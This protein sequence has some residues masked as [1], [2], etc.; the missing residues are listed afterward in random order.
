MQSGTTEIATLT[1]TPHKIN[2]AIAAKNSLSSVNQ[3]KPLAVTPSKKSNADEV[4]PIKKT[5]VGE[6]EVKKA[7]KPLA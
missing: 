5:T 4:T 7:V 2:P 6:T 1:S 3:G